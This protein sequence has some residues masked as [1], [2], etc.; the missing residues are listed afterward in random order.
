MLIMIITDNLM[1]NTKINEEYL[2]KK[3]NYLFY[4][5]FIQNFKM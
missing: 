5:F 3:Q 4:N 1:V 2:K